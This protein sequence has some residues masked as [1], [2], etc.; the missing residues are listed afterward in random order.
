MP[1]VVSVMRIAI[2]EVTYCDRLH[3]TTQELDSYTVRPKNKE[4]IMYAFNVYSSA[5]HGAHQPSDSPPAMP[6]HPLSS[7][8]VQEVVGGH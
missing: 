8:V 5:L 7:M 3:T 1:N 2:S 4:M 6:G